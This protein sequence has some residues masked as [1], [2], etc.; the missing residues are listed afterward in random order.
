M[1][2]TEAVARIKNRGVVVDHMKVSNQTK[3]IFLGVGPEAI[4]YA[5][6]MVGLALQWAVIPVLVL[7]IGFPAAVVLLVFLRLRRKRRDEPI[8]KARDARDEKPGEFWERYQQRDRHLNAVAITFATGVVIWIAGLTTGT[9]LFACG[10]LIL[11]AD[12]YLF[13]PWAYAK[14]GGW[15]SDSAS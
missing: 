10:A 12:Q 1:L 4:A 6:M 11:L 7:G 8:S 14:V 9:I 3:A 5:I 2:W 15:E 13:A